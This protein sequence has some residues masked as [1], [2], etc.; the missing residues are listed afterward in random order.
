MPSL[1]L[2]ISEQRHYDKDIRGWVEWYVMSA[3]ADYQPEEWMSS[4]GIPAE[5]VPAVEEA[6]RVYLE[7]NPSASADDTKED[8]AIVTISV[9]GYLKKEI[10][11]ITRIQSGSS[12]TVELEG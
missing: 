8:P 3:N 10:Y 4:A 1:G 6:Y 11:R 2:W 9:S 7:R 5:D 12:A